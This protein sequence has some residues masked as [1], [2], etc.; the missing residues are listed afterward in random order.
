MINSMTA[1][2]SKELQ[3]DSG[4]F[5][6]ELRSVNHR[7]RD[8]H[9]R[10][11]DMFR[12]IEP[13]IRDL[14]KKYISRGRIECFLYYRPGLSVAES[15]KVNIAM[16][17]ELKKADDEVKKIFGE[18]ISKNLLNILR[19]PGA[20]Q[21]VEQDKTEQQQKIL[22][23]FEL[24]VKELN[25]VREREGAALEKLIEQRLNEVNIL[26]KSINEMLP[27]IIVQQ[28]KR[29]LERFEEI[30]QSLDSERLEQEMVFYVNRMDVSEELDRLQT[31]LKET[32]RI[33]KEGGSCGRHLDF[34]MQEF[35]REANTMGSKSVSE[36]T[37]KVAMELKVLIEQ[38]REQIQ[39]IE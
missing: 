12:S 18:T 34:M 35:N 36:K 3:D 27:E 4:L 38:M 17:K 11:P 31:H 5:K 25:T 9:I 13:K 20:T 28:K 14:L 8:A 24:A 10:L 37:T 21:V 33:L 7:Y 19:F 29:L 22:D 23:I 39:N 26:L 15:I 16:L 32:R 1:F 2:A 6:W 30:K